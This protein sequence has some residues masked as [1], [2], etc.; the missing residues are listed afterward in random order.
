[1]LL[2]K[3]I[4]S[5]IIATILFDVFNYVISYAYSIEKPKWNLVG[6]YFLGYK[7]NVYIRTNINDDV[8]ENNELFFGYLIHY[9][10]GIIYGIFYVLLNY[11]LFDYPSILLAYIIG[12]LTVL[13]SWCFMMPFAY[14]LGFFASK[15]EKRFILM[16]QNLI[17][18]FVFGT[19]LF[20]G[21]Y[22][23]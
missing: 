22:I 10:I 6:R 11:I 1:M 7:N 20:I 4:F 14:N 15:N 13:G 23:L 8:E 2:F 3:G 17:A 18:H 19:G 12:F 16:T 5:G 21:Y 9:L